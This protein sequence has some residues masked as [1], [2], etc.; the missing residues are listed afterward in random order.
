MLQWIESIFSAMFGL[1]VGSFINVCI[2]RIPLQFMTG[3][4][5]QKLMESS[6]VSPVIKQYLQ[7]NRIN[8]AF[9]VRSLCFSCGTQ[10]AWFDNIPVFSFLLSRGRC[11]YCEAR[12]GIRSLLV[13]MVHG[14]CGGTLGFFCSRGM[15]FLGILHLAVGMLTTL[16][17]VEQKKMIPVLMSVLVILAGLDLL[18]WIYYGDPG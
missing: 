17:I 10:L 4:E 1:A 3:S 16:T 12:Y 2:D 11:R 7:N 13:E 15:M 9:P 14:V 18:V 6:S 5:K 8:I